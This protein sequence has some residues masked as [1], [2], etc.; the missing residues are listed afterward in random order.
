MVLASAGIFI[1]ILNSESNPTYKISWIIPVALLPF[2]GS[3]LYLLS[4]YNIGSIA[5]TK[6]V[7]QSL[8]D[9]EKY[10]RT[11]PEVRDASRAKPEGLR[12]VSIHRKRRRLCI[13]PQHLR[14]VFSAGRRR[15][16]EIVRQLERRNLLFFSNFSSFVKESSGIRFWK[17][18]RE[19]PVPA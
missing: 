13:L 2:F 5:S 11:A 6:A 4:H 19:K 14:K 18:C 12:A 17:S 8:E 15:F 9:T 10:S 1:V 7:R 16:P 3:M